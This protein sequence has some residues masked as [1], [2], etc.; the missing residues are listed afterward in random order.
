MKQNNQL[1]ESD[2]QRV[3]QYLD[4]PQRRVE[5]KPFR[6][7]LLLGSIMV[8]M[9]LLSLFSYFLAWKEGVI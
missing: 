1:T 9:A 8:I 4:R 3:D 6:P 7:W 2:Q 5:R